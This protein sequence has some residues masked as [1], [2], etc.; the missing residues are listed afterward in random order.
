M[1]ARQEGGDSEHHN[2]YSLASET[3]AI[4]FPWVAFD[5]CTQ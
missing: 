2:F 5:V 4:Q 1:T 3:Q